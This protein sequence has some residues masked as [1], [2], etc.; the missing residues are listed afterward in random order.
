MMTEGQASAWL[1]ANAAAY[2]KSDGMAQWWRLNDGSWVSKVKL[3]NGM[4]ELRRHAASS[5]NCG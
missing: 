5:C 2:V 3:S 1:I 4:Y